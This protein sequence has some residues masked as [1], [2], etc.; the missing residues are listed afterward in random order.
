MFI[1]NKNGNANFLDGE[2]DVQGYV[3]EGDKYYCDYHPI[4]KQAGA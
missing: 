3:Y 2:Y 1:V 4:G